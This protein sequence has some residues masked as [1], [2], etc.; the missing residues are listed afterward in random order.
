M[1]SYKSRALI[2]DQ[3]SRLWVVA[4]TALS[5]N[6]CAAILI[7][8]YAEYRLRYVPLDVIAFGRVLGTPMPVV[9]CLRS[10]IWEHL[11]ML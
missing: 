9:L 4:L 11:E 7:A 1:F 8:E 3:Q 6:V 5:L 2:E 10:N